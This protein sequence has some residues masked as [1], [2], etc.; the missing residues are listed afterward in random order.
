MIFKLQIQYDLWLAK[1]K[2][3]DKFS[4][5]HTKMELSAPIHYEEKLFE[6]MDEE[7]KEATFRRE[8][9]ATIH[10]HMLK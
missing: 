6:D 4:W 3:T 8:V 7:E 5:G 10:E 2:P 9:Y 1:R